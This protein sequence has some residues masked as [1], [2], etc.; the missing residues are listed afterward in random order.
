LGGGAFPTLI[1]IITMFF[2]RVVASPF[3]SLVSTLL[4][5]GVIVYA[6]QH[7]GQ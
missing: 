7:A 1:A 4:L 5:T 6:A 3:Q 2:A